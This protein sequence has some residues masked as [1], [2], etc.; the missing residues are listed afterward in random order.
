MIKNSQDFDE[1][2]DDYR[3]TVFFCRLILQTH[4]NPLN[5]SIVRAIELSEEL[6]CIVMNNGIELIC[7][8]AC[9]YEFRNILIKNY[10][11]LLRTD[12]VYLRGFSNP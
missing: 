2:G 7:I 12:F 4:E 3:W 9:R 11:A 1:M 5:S 10:R 6:R 8:N